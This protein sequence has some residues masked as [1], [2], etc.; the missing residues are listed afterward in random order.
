MPNELADLRFASDATLTAIAGVAILL[1]ALVALWAEIRRV[2][3]KH[4]D[5]VGW[6]P[7]TRVFFIAMLVGLTLLTMAMQGWR[8]G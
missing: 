3:R 2:K 8:T 5:A 6:V 7:W 1:V 4:I